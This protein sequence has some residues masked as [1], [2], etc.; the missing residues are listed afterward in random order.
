MKK[1]LYTIL[2]A[3]LLTACYEDKGN[4]D[5]ALDQMNEI[6]NVRFTPGAVETIDGQTIEVQQPLSENDRVK[7]IEVSMDQS[8]ASNIDNLD[9]IWTRTYINEE[10]LRVKDSLYTPGYMEV[11]LP[12]GK[13]MRYDVL[14][15]IKDKT[16]TLSN[17]TNFV[18]KTRPIYKNSLFV[19]HGSQGARKLGN[20]EVVGADTKVRMD[21]YQTVYPEGSDMFNHAIALSYSTYYDLYYMKESNNLSVYTSDGRAHVFE[22]FGLTYKFNPNFVVPS[23]V[24]DFVFSRNVEAGD[25]GN[26]RFYRCVLSR[27]GA[28]YTGNYIPKLYKPYAQMDAYPEFA[29]PN[30]QSDYQV[31]AVAITEQRFV[32]WDAKN[33]RFLYLSKSDGYAYDEYNTQNPYLA[34]SQPVLDAY[35]DFSHMPAEVSPVGKKAVYAY[36]NYRE[37]YEEAHPFFIFKDEVTGK[38]YQYELTS[39]QTGDGKGD[40]KSVKGKDDGKEEG[41]EPAF[42]I[43]YKEMRNF[44]PGENLALICYNSYFTTNYIF[45]ADGANVYR[46]NISNGDKNL[47]Y[48]APVGYT[49]GVMKF[50]TNSA[51]IYNDDLGYILSL[52]LNKGSEGAVAEI[53]LNTAS[54][55]DEEFE[56]L[57][58]NQS[59]DGEKFGNIQ[60]LQF[61]HV[62]M[63]KI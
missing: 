32:M 48:T 1:T 42:S 61:A 16:T 51:N 27:N 41:N 21:A 57:F 40:G 49:I 22:P 13:E 58:Y 63:Y 56:P 15:E 33:N 5:Y 28:F 35:V 30:H 36:I 19:L 47:I 55:L 11:E 59:E 26:Y 31:T 18:I 10:G 62:Y 6:T 8:L 52:G 43:S 23:G 2:V 46:Y 20:I 54:D 25:P 29:D 3:S 4:Y 38:F 7:R 9:F 37:N 39:L 45:Y 12:V 14:L 17:Y 50:R 44:Q 34:L 24:T 53:K 60:D